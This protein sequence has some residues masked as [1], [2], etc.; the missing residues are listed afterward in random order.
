M[1][2]KIWV[3]TNRVSKIRVTKNID[4]AY[5]AVVDQIMVD[6]GNT[7]EPIVVVNN[8]LKIVASHSGRLKIVDNWIT[9]DKT[10]CTESIFIVV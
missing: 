3:N 1:V 9:K 7:V 10:R 6:V 2:N 4:N 5:T 8:R